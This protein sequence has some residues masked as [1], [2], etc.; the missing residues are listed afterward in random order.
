[1][2]ESLSRLGLL[3]FKKEEKRAPKPKRIV[4]PEDRLIQSFYARRPEVK[5]ALLVHAFLNLSGSAIGLGSL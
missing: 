5:R 2:G 1:L 4:F 3:H